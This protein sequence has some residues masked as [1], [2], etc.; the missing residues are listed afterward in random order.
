MDNNSLKKSTFTGIL[1]KL[2]ERVGTQAVSLIV[3][4]VLARLLTAE[5][6]G[7]VGIVTIFFNLANVLI[8]SGFNTALIQK[9][10]ADEEDYS[11]VLYLTLAA[12]MLLYIILFFTAPLIAAA[13][14]M[15]VLVSVLRVMGITVIINGVM[16]VVS[17]YVSSQ[18]KFRK[19][20]F[21]TIGGILVSAVVGIVMALR[22]FGPWALVAQQMTS[23][24]IGTVILLLTSKI[25]FVLRFSVQK[26][27]GLF[28]YG[29][30]ILVSGII[31]TAYEETNPLIIGLRFS[32][33]DLS[34]YTKGR[35]FPAL[36]SNSV[37]DSLAAVLFPVIS[38]VQD[39][40]EAVLRYT[41]RFIR[42]SS[43][44]IF[45]IMFGFIAVSDNF[46]RVVLTEKWLPA[47]IYIQIFCLSYMFMMI[48]NGNLQAIRAIGR[49]DIILILEI[50]KKS[51][52][53]IVILLFVLFSDK[54]ELL[55]VAMV[56]NTLLATLINTFPNRRLI[57]YRYRMQIADLLPN[58]ILALVMGAVVYSM[59]FIEMNTFLLLILQLIAG[60]G[61]YLALSILTKNESFSYLLGY[62]KGF[63]SKKGETK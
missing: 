52:Y 11:S 5:D 13:Y 53:F 3:S 43:Y 45:P 2:A 9:K 1:W 58:F 21:S 37:S 15:P 30:K 28:S 34:Y 26:I 62:L 16:S 10:D 54:P 40:M 56:I 33:A 25:K 19:F 22:G 38:K 51:L 20:F 44:L 32:G 49:S 41:R 8:T 36:I 57:G 48:Q 17:A 14:S 39:D 4:I 35:N 23:T 29:W 61:I 24:I 63:I 31:S 55:A 47:S 42:V 50:V 7:V 59:N 60:V 18:L 46:V 6:Y 12:S 27:K